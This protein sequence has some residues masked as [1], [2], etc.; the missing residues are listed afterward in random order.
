MLFE[1]NSISLLHGPKQKDKWAKRQPRKNTNPP[2]PLSFSQWERER[3]RA[4]WCW[5]DFLWLAMASGTRQCLL[6]YKMSPARTVSDCFP[7]HWRQTGKETKSCMYLLP[8][9][10]LTHLLQQLMSF[11]LFSQSHVRNWW[12]GK[13]GPV[14]NQWHALLKSVTSNF[15][16]AV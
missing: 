9:R 6:P 7:S 3:E 8:M 11:V 13:G 4:D 2:P 1:E 14:I 10:K 16:T 15:S 5:A 12:L